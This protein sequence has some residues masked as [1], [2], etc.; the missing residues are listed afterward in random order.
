VTPSQKKAELSSPATRAEET[1]R[2][3]VIG[4]VMTHIVVRSE[5]PLARGSDRRAKIR[6][7]PG[8]PAANQAAGLAA[9][10]VAVD[11]VARVGAA[12]VEA[13]SAR[14]RRA[15]VTPHLAGDPDRPTG[16]L[17]ALIGPSGERSSSPTAA[18]T[19]R[20]SAPTFPALID[21]TSLIHLSG[22]AFFAPFR[23]RPRSTSGSGRVNANRGRPGLGRVSS[24]ELGAR[25]VS[26]ATIRRAEPAALRLATTRT[27]GPA[28]PMS[29]I[30]QVEGSDG[31][32][33]ALPPTAQRT[34]RL[35]NGAPFPP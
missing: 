15:G 25:L 34:S 5:G 4:D 9:F 23:R 10:G 35:A 27:E 33:L 21:S 31:T 18:Q 11:F 16:R 30:A 26:T 24:L 2:I 14:L 8:G 32:T 20:S 13:E 17:V 1:P 12:D 28:K 7:E 29:I 19:R 6:F 3:L 22:Y